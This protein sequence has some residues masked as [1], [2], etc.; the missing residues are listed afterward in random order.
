MFTIRF[1]T[2]LFKIDLW[3]VLMLPKSA[4]A[5]L[6]SRGM[7]MVE[8]TIN[9]FRFQAAL[10]PDGKG[11][12][13]FRVDKAMRE[14]ADAGAGDTVVLAIQPTRVWPEPAVPADF[15]HALAVV[16]Q[17]HSIWIDITPMA[18]WDWIRWI[19]STKRPETRMRRIEVA[20]SKLKAGNRRPCCFNRNVCTVPCVCNKG[21]L[22]EHYNDSLSGS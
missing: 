22:F 3:T 19:R 11:S 14:A 6:P 16:P 1:K 7:T 20:C 21:V 15:K 2:T 10:E 12:H 18:R 5:K 17:A 9:G 4:S 8:G 13:W